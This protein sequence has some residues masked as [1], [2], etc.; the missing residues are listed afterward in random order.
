MDRRDFL[1]TAFNEIVLVSKDVLA[2]IIAKDIEKLD[3]STDMLVG[4]DWKCLPNYQLDGK[5][6][7]VKTFGLD[8]T[9]FFVILSENGE[10]AIRKQCPTCKGMLTVTEFDKK[11]KCFI[12][13]KSLSLGTNEGDLQVDRVNI[14]RKD[15]KLE[16]LA[17]KFF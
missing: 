8:K 9:A 11:C 10:T 5:S 6:W 7:A 15:G 4:E 17:K 13:D 16:Y 14:R 12:C 3:K 2:P 1:K